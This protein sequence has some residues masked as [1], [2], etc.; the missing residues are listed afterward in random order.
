MEKCGNMREVKNIG[1]LCE[2]L[3]NE[4]YIS[5]RWFERLSSSLDSKSMISEIIARF[6]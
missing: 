2:C 1:M 4:Y 6:Y 3:E 5:N